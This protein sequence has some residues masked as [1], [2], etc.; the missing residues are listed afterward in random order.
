MPPLSLLSQPHVEEYAPR[1]FEEEFDAFETSAFPSVQRQ[2][3]DSHFR[4]FLRVVVDW[5]WLKTIER[6]LKSHT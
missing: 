4:W 2:V 5:R 6:V 1:L 3:R